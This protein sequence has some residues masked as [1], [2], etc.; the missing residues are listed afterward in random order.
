MAIG[1]DTSK[2]KPRKIKG[3]P[4]DRGR[5]ILG[6]GIIGF[7]LICGAFYQFSGI[8]GKFRKALD[9]FYEDPIEEVERRQLIVSGLPVRT[10][11]KIRELL[12]DAERPDR[13]DK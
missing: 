5:N 3:T 7:G 9:N 10:G 12:E 4:A 1:I 11:D 8:T 13:P 2:W 6:L